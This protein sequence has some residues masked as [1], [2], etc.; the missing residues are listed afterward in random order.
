MLA[1]SGMLAS[2][3]TFVS[4]GTASAAEYIPELQWPPV[5][6][7]TYSIYSQSKASPQGE[8]TL[9]CNAYETPQDLV[10]HG[11]TGSET[12][13]LPH[14]Q[15][16]D[17][18]AN[19]IYNI[20]IDKNGD[21]YG[22]PR[23]SANLL[24]YRGNTLK[25]KYPLGCTYYMANP[26]VGA[27]GNVYAINGSGRL[28]GVTPEVEPGKTQ[29]KKVLDV[30]ASNARCS[31]T[32]LALKDGLV[33]V[34]NMKATFYS[35]SG[36][37]LGTTPS[38]AIVRSENDPISASGR[39]FY[40]NYIESGGLRSATI[41][42]YDYGRKETTWTSTVSANGAYVYSAEAHA[43]P[44]G[45]AAVYLREKEQDPFSA[46]TGRPAY[47][48]VK[49]NAFGIV[50]WRKNLPLGDAGQNQFAEAEVKVDVN[51]NIIVAR[52]GQLKTNDSYNADVEGISIAVFGSDGTVVYDEVMRGNLDKNTGTVDGYR[53]KSGTLQPAPG[54]L[55]FAAQP[56]TNGCFNTIK[57][58]PLKVPSLGLDYP[59]G[60]TLAVPS[61]LKPYVALGDSFSSGQGA[62][63][64]DSNTVTDANK[65]YKSYS[66]YGRILSR[67]TSNSLVLT[68]F[69]ACGGAVADNI[70]TN[71]TY[72]GVPSPQNSALSS[73]TK[74]VSLSIGGNDIGFADVIM[75]CA[76]PT[77]DCDGAFSL[78][79][80]QLGMLD[81]MLQR[82]YLDIL[83]KAP[84]AKV[85]I[86]G[87]PP[88]VTT[89]PG[90]LVGNNGT[91]YPFFSES[92]K[93]KAVDL[94]HSLN[95][96][97]QSSINTIRSLSTDYDQRLRFI[98]AQASGSPFI[99]HDVCSS[100]PYVNGLILLP[101]NS[102][103]SFH[104]NARGHKA[105]ADLLLA[106]M[107]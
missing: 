107:D 83:K 43:T 36:V 26:T 41:S 12:R 67:D 101:G 97:T 45:G 103:E 95:S 34:E 92:R 1:L 29:P 9:G 17:G 84:D 52:N 78:A 68:N 20:A 13:R 94:A 53:L 7:G 80:N 18:V 56:C 64:Y 81:N 93:Q 48:I 66:G 16:V 3:V 40:D 39:V 100:E 102:S 37:N 4:V 15:Q 42:A 63:V 69:A 74:V 79:Y 61:P 82:V 14:A 51:G 55:Y 72:P 38:D 46:I 71:T 50:Q 27:D 90:C 24:A 105:Y 85:Y 2:L 88:I 5:Q 21:L 62:G 54:V 91:D 28:I 10:T 49:V 60:A 86:L 96:T 70:D 31:T 44:D 89:G 58:Y 6:V 33:T 73:T 35:Y 57:L 65:C 30:P 23:Q 87:Y 75:T 32:L 76:N 99:G 19:C 22:S 106:N 8:L 77:K 11:P 47:N 25:W 104:P 98:D 59:R